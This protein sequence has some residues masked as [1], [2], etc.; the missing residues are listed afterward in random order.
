MANITENSSDDPWYKDLT[1]RKKKELEKQVRENEEKERA[2]ANNKVA[3]TGDIYDEMEEE[4]A[5]H[6]EQKKKLSKYLA[7]LTQ[8]DGR[9]LHEVNQKRQAA[10]QA[11][12]NKGWF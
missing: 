2:R 10:Q 9:G 3:P 11:R 1:N 6:E 7:F 12:K 4:I 5:R 8:K